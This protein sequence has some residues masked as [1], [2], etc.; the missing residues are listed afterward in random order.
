MFGAARCALGLIALVCPLVDNWLGKLSLAEIVWRYH[1]TP[2][3]VM[4][5][6]VRKEDILIFGV[7]DGAN[8][9]QR[10][11]SPGFH[12]SGDGQFQGCQ[13][14]GC[15]WGY[16]L[17]LSEVWRTRQDWTRDFLSFIYCG[18]G[19]RNELSCNVLSCNISLSWSS[20][21]IHPRH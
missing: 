19:R 4:D 9:C 13:S 6:A 15:A 5:S 10:G 16:N 20:N 3:K 2:I 14:Q 1:D 21:W 18:E 8:K 11:F 17:S 7:S 12:C